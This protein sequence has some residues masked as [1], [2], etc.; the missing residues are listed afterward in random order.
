MFGK[1]DLI[2]HLVGVRLDRLK[3]IQFILRPRTH[4][5]DPAESRKMKVIKVNNFTANVTCHFS[6]SET[7]VRTFFAENFSQRINKGYEDK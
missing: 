1:T 7:S 4:L 6:I 3:N 5:V 2:L